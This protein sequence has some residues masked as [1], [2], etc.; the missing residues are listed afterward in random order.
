MILNSL[1]TYIEL[2]VMNLIQSELNSMPNKKT[3]AEQQ[4]MTKHLW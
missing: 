2:I 3:I 4:A 1:M